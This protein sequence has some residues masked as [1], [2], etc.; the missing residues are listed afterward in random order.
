MSNELSTDD[1]TATVEDSCVQ[2][3]D[4]LGPDHQHTCA[5][6]G[7]DP[8][9]SVLVIGDDSTEHPV[10]VCNRFCLHEIDPDNEIL[11]DV[12]PARWAQD[13]VKKKLQQEMR[14]LKQRAVEVGLPWN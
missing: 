10:L 12:D 11:T 7:A 13:R 1:E 2:C 14:S 4:A 3:K 9:P 5:A 6:C 8:G